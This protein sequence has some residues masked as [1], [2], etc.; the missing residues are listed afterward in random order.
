MALCLNWKQLKSVKH[1]CYHSNSQL[2]T[3]EVH[4][5]LVCRVSVL[6]IVVLG[7]GREGGIKGKEEPIK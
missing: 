3:G 5:F 6:F 2:F 7:V 1:I 4:V